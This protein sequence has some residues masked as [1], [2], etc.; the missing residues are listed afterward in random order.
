VESTGRITL[1]SGARRVLSPVSS[2]LPERE[3]WCCTNETEARA[4]RSTGGVVSSCRPGSAAAPSHR[5]RCVV[6]ARGVGTLAVVVAPT[7][8]L[9][10]IG[11]HVAEAM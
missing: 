7:D 5:A 11:T 2:R 3:C 1:P 4:L 6:A 9:E 8:V 10:G